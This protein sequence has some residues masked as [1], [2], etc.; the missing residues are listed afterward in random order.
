V[1]TLAAVMACGESEPPAGGPAATAT[2]GTG[3]TGS[4]A[5]GSGGNGAS[6]TGGGGANPC[7]EGGAG[8]GCACDVGEHLDIQGQCVGDVCGPGDSTRVLFVGNSYTG[9]N[10][11]PSVF[12][13]LAASLGCVVDIDSS[14]IGGARFSDHVMSPE[15]ATKIDAGSWNHVVLQNQSQVPGWQ[16]ADVQAESV[17]HAVTLVDMVQAASPDASIA[18]FA[19]WGRRDGDADNCGYYPLVCTFE[20]HTQALAE[21]YALYAAATGGDIAP[22]GLG[23]QAVVDA[24]TA[25]FDPAELWAGDGSHPTIRG[26]YLAA[27]I[28]FGRIF[29][30]PTIGATYA[31]G[32]DAAD[33]AFMQATASGFSAQ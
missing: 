19:T 4:G 24:T 16:P 26:T 25:P 28:L 10:D 23:F 12:G 8:G 3:A 29:A 18:Y 14:V 1:L 6:D 11:L 13:A 22:V 17:P 33:A 31:A 21:G 9:V 27:A 15:T 32:L 2:S 7:G 20:G 30:A 5:T